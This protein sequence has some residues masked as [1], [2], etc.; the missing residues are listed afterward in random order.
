[1]VVLRESMGFV[2]HIL[3]KAKCVTLSRES[4]RF[5]DIGQIDFFLS[6][7]QSQNGG[8]FDL[9]RGKSIEDRVELTSAPINQKQ[10]GKKLPL[11]LKAVKPPAHHFAQ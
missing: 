4:D 1:M 2:A 8:R 3:Q 5:G 6:L 10:I 11:C 7:R 9:Q